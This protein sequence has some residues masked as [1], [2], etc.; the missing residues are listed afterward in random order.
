MIFVVSLFLECHMSD[1]PFCSWLYV[2]E[3]TNYVSC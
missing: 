2:C 1:N 3:N